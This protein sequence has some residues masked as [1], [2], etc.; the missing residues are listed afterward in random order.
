MLG[1]SPVSKY[2]INLT[3]YSNELTKLPQG[4]EISL[5]DPTKRRI[6]WRLLPN[7]LN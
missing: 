7:I 5:S 2:R 1:T 4:I 6:T 3:A